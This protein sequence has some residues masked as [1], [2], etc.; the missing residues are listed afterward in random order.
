MVK[1]EWGVEPGKFEFRISTSLSE[2][3]NKQHA[4]FELK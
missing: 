4:R 1:I 2:V 3:D